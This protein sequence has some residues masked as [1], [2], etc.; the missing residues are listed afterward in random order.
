MSNKKILNIIIIMVL[1]VFVMTSVS[2]AGGVKERMKSRL[3]VI[4]ALKEKGVI[5]ENNRGYLEVLS[6]KKEK[7][8][9]VK[10]ENKD[11]KIVYTAIAKKQNSNSENVGERRALQISKKAKPG[12]MLQDKKGKWYKK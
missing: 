9:V 10:A 6:E 1:C 5:G 7:E 2:F 12:T 3:P 8:D 11:R 4:R